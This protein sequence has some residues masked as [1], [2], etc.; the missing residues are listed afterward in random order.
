MS[1]ITPQI[2]SPNGEPAWEAAFLLPPQGRW[3]E[4]DFLELHTNRMAELVDGRL[5]ILPMPTLQHQRILR[6]LLGLVEKAAPGGSTVLFAPLPTRL[7]PG[8]IREPDLLYIAPENA[9][10]PNE[11]YPAHIDLAVEIVSEGDEARRRDYDDKRT[12]YAKAGVSEYWIV[13]PQD[14]CVTV[15]VLEGN[16]YVEVKVFRIGEHAS[17]RLLP[18]LTVDVAEL[19]RQ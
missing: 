8:T 11:K 16:S 4:A 12:D 9:P 19:L 7:F 10:A 2:P 1:T 15:L 17:G 3:N 6:F 14:E 18:K 13:D 5:E